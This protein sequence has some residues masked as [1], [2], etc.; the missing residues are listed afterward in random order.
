V[1]RTRPANE[2]E[3][4]QLISQSLDDVEDLPAAIEYDEE[5]MGDAAFLVKP[6]SAELNNLSTAI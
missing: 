1:V 5:F 4:L 3:F 2:T 6:L